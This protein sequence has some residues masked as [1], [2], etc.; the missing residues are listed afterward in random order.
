MQRLRSQTPSSVSLTPNEVSAILCVLFGNT[1][2][3]LFLKNREFFCYGGPSGPKP[4]GGNYFILNLLVWSYITQ[5]QNFIFLFI[6][7]SICQGL[8]LTTKSRRNFATG[9]QIE[10]SI[11]NKFTV[12]FVNCFRY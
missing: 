9:Y 8:K 4:C 3:A 5:L 1:L 11:E 10:L 12:F 6:S 7:F 2:R